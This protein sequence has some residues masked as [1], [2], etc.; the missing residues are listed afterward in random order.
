MPLLSPFSKTGYIWL[1]EALKEIKEFTGQ[2][3]MVQTGLLKRLFL[4][5]QPAM[6][7]LSPFS[8]TSC[9]WLGEG[10]KEIKE[11]IGQVLM[12]QAGLLNG[13]FVI[14]QQTRRPLLQSS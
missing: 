2:A 13:A 14:E 4:I 7:L 12:V 11:F 9:I 8:K 1:G 10:L 3:L 6:L 5:E